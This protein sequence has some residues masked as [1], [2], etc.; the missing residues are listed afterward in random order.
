MQDPEMKAE[1]EVNDFQLNKT[2]FGRAKI[3]GEWDKEL[4]GVRLLADMKEDTLSTTHVTGYVSPK[5]KGLDLHIQAGGTNLAFLRPFVSGIMS[6]RRDVYTVSCG[7]TD[8][9]RRSI[10]K[11]VPWP[12]PRPRLMC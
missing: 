8:R 5:L 1:L 6:N 10:W 11:G 4:G 2:S 7:C 3:H 12:K 9:S